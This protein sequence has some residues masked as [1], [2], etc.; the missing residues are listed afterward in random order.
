MTRTVD[1]VIVG[2]DAA[3]VAATI[4]SLSRGFRVLVVMR[5]QRSGFA[6]DIRRAI[7]ATA[8]TSSQLTI[9]SGAEVVCVDGVKS[10]EAVVVR[11]LR[12]RRLIGINTPALCVFGE[13]P[14]DEE[15]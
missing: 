2:G 8:L 14:L 15:H 7:G 4:D 3:A 13:R 5:Q 11:R 1:V 12:T 10:I 6:R 9:L